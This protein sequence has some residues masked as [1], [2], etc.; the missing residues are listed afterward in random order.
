MATDDMQPLTLLS[1]TPSPFARMNIIALKLKSIPF[2]LKNEIPWHASTETPRYNPLEKLPVLLFPDG[3]AP[4]YDSSHIQEYI[5]AKYADRGPNLITGDM[6]L[7]LEM[8]QIVVLAQGC[9]DAV[10]LSNFEKARE[11]GKRSGPWL[12]RQERKIDGA[13]KAMAALVTPGKEFLVGEELSIA[14][15]AVSVAVLAVEFMGLREGWKDM[16]PRLSEWVQGMDER[17]EWVETRPVMFDLS[18]AVV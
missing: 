3:R 15:I 18:E 11:E 4:V 13:M 5:V 8:R 14:D 1:A 10:V 12:A 7:D 9:L 6:D 17:R 16:Y 2:E